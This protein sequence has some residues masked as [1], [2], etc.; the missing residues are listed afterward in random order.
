MRRSLVLA[1]VA[2]C[3]SSSP[4]A[5]IASV[6]WAYP[7]NPTTTAPA[8]PLDL[9]TVPD[10]RPS[11]HGAMPEVVAHGRKPDVFACGFCHLPTGN[12]RPE[13][14]ALAG[15]PRE[16]IASQMRHFRDG[17]RASSIP[18]R[19]PTDAMLRSAKAATDPE[20]AAAADYFARQRHR[21]FV[22]VVE[23][24]T[25]PKTIVAG[26]IYRR[27]P[28]GGTEPLGRR[29]VEMPDDI[30]RFE[31]RDPETAYTAYVPPGSVALGQ[32]LAR[33]WGPSGTFA[34]SACHGVDLRGVANI[35]PIAGRSPTYLV[36]QLRD[37]QTGARR[38]SD[39]ALMSPV[40]KDMTPD[41]MIALAAFLAS[42]MTP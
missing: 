2:A 6:D 16:Y 23:A 38:G 31:R 7:V 32:R 17:S 36:R 25:I 27:D 1:V 8:V 28:A 3:S 12:G 33:G 19:L 4:D 37:L 14:A 13:N 21:S 34:C 5:P 35:P 26:W 22:R 40:V 29:I 42:R 11:D 41:D 15:L 39:A 9:F 10:P 18:G 24:D 30:E 20:I